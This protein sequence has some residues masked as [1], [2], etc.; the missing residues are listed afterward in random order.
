MFRQICTDLL[1]AAKLLFAPGSFLVAE[2]R[3]VAIANAQRR[4]VD[5]SDRASAV[6]HAF[7]RSATLVAVSF[8]FGMAI[9]NVVDY[10]GYALLAGWQQRL[11][12]LSAAILLWGTV[13]VRGW[14]IQTYG[15]VSLTERANR[16]LYLTL[17]VAGTVL[18]VFAT[19]C[20]ALSR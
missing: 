9:A 15:G 6:R 16:T 13:F 8:L 10:A 5:V 3:N 17:Y 18:G 7:L 4:G 1:N 20:P 19:L 12:A 14:E 11:Q 2:D